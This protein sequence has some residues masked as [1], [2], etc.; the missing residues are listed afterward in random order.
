M[1][2]H[3]VLHRGYT[4][5]LRTPISNPCPSANL[6]LSISRFFCSSTLR[7]AGERLVHTSA[8]CP[9]HSSFIYMCDHVCIYVCICSIIYI[10]IYMC[11]YIDIQYTHTC[12]CCFFIQYAYIC[13]Q[14]YLYVCIFV[15]TVLEYTRLTRCPGEVQQQLRGCE[16]RVPRGPLIRIFLTFSTSKKTWIVC[17]IIGI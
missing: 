17:F 7:S 15:H 5:I 12:R 13:F 8:N 11:V 9:E 4:I 16:T 10:Y 6:H 14:T 3:L 1:E 2:R